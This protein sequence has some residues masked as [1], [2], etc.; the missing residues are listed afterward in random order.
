MK[1]VVDKLTKRYGMITALDQVSFELSGSGIVGFVGANGAGKTTALRI[2]CALEEPDSGDVLL[3]GVSMIDYPEKMRRRIGFMPDSLP[4]A[5]DI[6]VKEY[7]EFFINSFIEK[8]KRRERFDEMAEF[9]GVAAFLPRKLA[10]LS[11]GM[12]Q[13]VSLARLLIHDPELL[14]LD[15]PAAGLDPRGR[16]ELY[17]MLKKLADRGK[18]IF[19]SSHILAELENMV[20]SVVIIDRGRVLRYGTLETAVA[21]AEAPFEKIS[22]NALGDVSDILVQELVMRSGVRNLVRNGRIFECE[23]ECVNFARLLIAMGECRFP[24]GW[25]RRVDRT[26]ELEK[27]FLDVTGREV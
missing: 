3:D 10:E 27:L 22:F 14:L 23:I 13:R 1:L 15:E 19:L 7:L 18:M 24:V 12:K 6:T 16:I 11:K 25:L 9:S 2:M 17:T 20:D 4:D 26:V 21:A 5:S 8:D